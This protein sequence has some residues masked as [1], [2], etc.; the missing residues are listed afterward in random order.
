MPLALSDAQ[1]KTVMLFAAA[2]PPEKRSMFLERIGAMLA[3]RGRGHFND[4]DVAEV[5]QLALTG[6]VPSVSRIA[7][8][9]GR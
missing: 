1:L 4:D 7:A 9:M 2:I 5:A 6:L 3:A 8:S